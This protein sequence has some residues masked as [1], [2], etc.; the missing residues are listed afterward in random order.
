MSRIEWWTLTDAELLSQCAID[1]Y[2][3]SGP[4]GQKRNKTDSA[5][6]LR[7]EPT[8]IIVTATESRSQHENRRRGLRRLREELAYQRRQPLGPNAVAQGIRKSLAAGL[9]AS[10]RNPHFLPLAA[11][12]LD[13]LDEHHGQVSAAAAAL[14]VSTAALVKFLTRSTGLWR[15]A[16]QIRIAHALPPLRS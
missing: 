15:A 2:R 5:V 14:N 4:G 3:A 13:L 12:I 11:L 8:G 1:R 7:H 16:Q 9:P 10:P 6:R